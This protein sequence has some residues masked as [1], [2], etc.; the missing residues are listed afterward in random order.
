MPKAGEVCWGLQG[1]RLLNSGGKSGPN[2]ILG[3]FLQGK[4]LTK[5]LLMFPIGGRSEH[6]FEGLTPDKRHRY[7]VEER[8]G[9]LDAFLWKPGLCNR[10]VRSSEPPL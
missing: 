2:P 3:C 8:R 7:L 10:V 6:F 1:A 9:I 4:W 5:Q